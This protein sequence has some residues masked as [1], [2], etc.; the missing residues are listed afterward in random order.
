LELHSYYYTQQ[1]HIQIMYI[2]KILKETGEISK[3]SYIEL[4]DRLSIIMG[5][6]DEYC[7]SHTA[8]DDKVQ[9]LIDKAMKNLWD[10]YQITA[11]KI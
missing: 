5:N 7:Y 9:R 4:A 6:L 1:L 3:E 2:K 11:E 10:A 8:A